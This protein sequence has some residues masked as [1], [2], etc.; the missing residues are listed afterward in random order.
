MSLYLAGNFFRNTLGIFALFFA[1]IVAVDIIEFSRSVS[2]LDNV[3]FSAV[4]WVV[5][6]RAPS[7]AENVLPFCVMFGASASLIMLN[8]RLELVVARASGVSVWQFL[9]PIAVA[10]AL[11]GGVASLAYNPLALSAS[12]LSSAEE[13]QIY[14]RGKK[15]TEATSNGS[16]M[17]FN[18]NN[19]DVILRAQIA[20]NAGIDLTNVTA[21]RFDQN[22]E[23]VER[24]DAVT[25]KFV[26]SARHGNHYVLNDL[27]STRPGLKSEQQKQSV[28]PVAISKSQLQ[29]NQTSASS[30][31][32]W[33]LKEQAKRVELAGK[34]PLPF[35]TKFQALLAV[36]LLFVAM[37]LL[38]STVSL[39]FARFGI[40][41]KAILAG[42]LAGFVLYV[43]SKLLVTFGSNGLVPPFV[44]AWSA[45]IVASL[46]G[47]TVLLH[48]EDG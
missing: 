39:R 3:G 48:Q 2:G 19:G 36:P 41:G 26:E 21:Y 10:A 13:A 7:F 37:V 35:L 16:W 33:G 23:M 46:I 24:I 25:A 22:G 6:L 9:M 28:L 14:V 44:A 15:K 27:T 40:N 47:I 43:I 8:R 29:A 1:L 4:F 5:L 42:I 20:Q 34:N 31:G 45:A 17:R 12:V 11:L 38:A 32:F 30:V 18:Q